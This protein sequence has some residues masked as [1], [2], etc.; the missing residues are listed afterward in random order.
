MQ[1]ALVRAGTL[2]R[3]HRVAVTVSES[4]P[5]LAV[6]AAAVAEALYILLDNAS[7]YS[8]VGS[9]ILVRVGREDDRMV[10]VEVSDDGP[11][12]PADMR[13]RVFEKFFRVPEREANDPRRQ[14]VGLGLSIARGLVEAQGGEIWVEASRSGG[15]TIVMT[16]PRWSIA[17]DDL[18]SLASVAG[19]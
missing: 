3:D 10:R 7:K 2:T 6:D 19:E 15:T 17:T 9:E 13:E 11:K 4:A 16:V 12:I 8:P 18:E 1:V 5:P 14:G